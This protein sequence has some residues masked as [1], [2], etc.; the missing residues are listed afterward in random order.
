M[1]W[2]ARLLLAEPPILQPP[3]AHGRRAAWADGMVSLWLAFHLAVSAPVILNSQS[4]VMWPQHLPLVHYR[5]NVTIHATPASSTYKSDDGDGQKSDDCPSAVLEHS[6]IKVRPVEEHCW[7][8][9]PVVNLSAARGQFASLQIILNGGKS[10]WIVDS[11]VAEPPTVALRTGLFVETYLNITTVS[12]CNGALG[13]WPDGLVPI[14]DAHHGELRRT[15]PLAV[16]ADENRALWLDIWVP[17]VEHT[18]Q[19]AAAGIWP[20][21]VTVSGQRRGQ[22][23]QH[24]LPYLLRVFD[25]GLPPVSSLRSAFGF[26]ISAMLKG[27]GLSAT[28]SA[29]TRSSL[30]QTYL[31]MVVAHRLSF[32]EFTQADDSGW[33]RKEWPRWIDYWGSF[34]NH[35]RA[36]PGGLGPRRTGVTAARLPSSFCSDKYPPTVA[37]NG[38]TAFAEK[39]VAEWQQVANQ[40]RSSGFD[41]HKMLYDYTVDEPGSHPSLNGTLWQCLN[42][43]VPLLRRADP[44]LQSLVTTD[45]SH[46]KRAGVNSSLI[47]IFVSD[48][49][50]LEVKNGS[51]GGCGFNGAFFERPG[52]HRGDYGDGVEVW[53]YQACSQTG[54]CGPAPGCESNKPHE[55]CFVG[56]PTDWAVDLSAVTN[57]I[58]GWQHFIYNVSGVLAP[59]LNGQMG[60]RDVWVSQLAHGNGDGNFMYPGTPQRIGGTTHIPVASMRLKLVRDGLG[61]FEYLRMLST[62]RGRDVTLQLASR[63]ATSMYNWTVDPMVLLETKA[64]IGEAIE[65]ALEAD[66]A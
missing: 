46:A 40:F 45:M 3:M 39:Q 15:L 50:F 26:D 6:L 64:A 42:A 4:R 63:V 66:G 36:M 53:S 25:F 14:R 33:I 57:R 54:N 12:N 65:T 27:H 9:T 19:Y 41:V 56:N 43:R 11:V 28:T 52:S 24:S 16:P 61:D 47:D 17:E 29:E 31:D 8:S 32:G 23:E 59:S 37:K 34:L 48:Q 13:R 7:P 60:E 22:H 1:R 18:A 35:S 30:T 5:S 10:G 2:D 49:Q 51:R 38:C 55:Y 62:L 21:I 44:A 20:G 58:A